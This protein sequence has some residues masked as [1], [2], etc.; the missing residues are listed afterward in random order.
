MPEVYKS[1]IFLLPNWF[2]ENTKIPTLVA[3]DNFSLSNS[4]ANFNLS[5]TIDAFNVKEDKSMVGVLG[6]SP[7]EVEVLV[8]I[9][10][11]PKSAL[12]LA[13]VITIMK[14]PVFGE[15]NVASKVVAPLRLPSFTLV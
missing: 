10:N 9:S 4:A 2:L 14:L 7:P 6:V 11:L 8:L 1:L 15:G 3:D 12:A 5:P 13:P